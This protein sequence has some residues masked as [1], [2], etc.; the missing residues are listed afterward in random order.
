LYK[1]LIIGDAAHA[2]VPFYGQ[3]MNCGF[4]DCLVLDELLDKYLKHNTPTEDCIG[5]V[6]EE[7][8]SYRNPDAE[9][10]CDLA[11]YNYIEMRSGVQDPVYLF[12]KKVEGFLYQLFPKSVMPLYSM[13]SFSRTRYSVAKLL[14]EQRTKYFV[15]LR[16][17]YKFGLFGLVLFI[18]RRSASRLLK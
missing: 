7:Y 11:L 6:L 17:I 4:E 8:S 2:M 15:I 9:A 3:G 16:L 13:V 5:R 1:G 12:R 14:H 18:L 10:M